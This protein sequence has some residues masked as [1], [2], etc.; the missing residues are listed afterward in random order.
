[1]TK[2]NMLLYPSQF[3]CV[4]II[5]SEFSDGNKEFIESGNAAF[6]CREINRYTGLV[7]IKIKR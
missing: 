7:L 3:I 1:M 5:P 4:P 2:P 6:G